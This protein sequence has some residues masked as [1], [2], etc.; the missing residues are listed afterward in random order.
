MKINLKNELYIKLTTTNVS[1][2]YRF[3]RPHGEEI[4]DKRREPGSQATL[5]D[6]AKLEFSQANGVVTFLPV[7]TWN[8]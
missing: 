6:E 5:S 2:E 1:I 3:V 8:I 4:G 7:P